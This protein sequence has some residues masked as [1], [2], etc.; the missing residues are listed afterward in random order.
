MTEKHETFKL[1]EQITCS[2]NAQGKDHV[3]PVALLGKHSLF[4]FLQDYSSH[5]ISDVKQLC[6]DLQLRFGC[7]L[8]NS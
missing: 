3:S 8:F 1:A 4:L 5:A 6:E 7:I 2:H